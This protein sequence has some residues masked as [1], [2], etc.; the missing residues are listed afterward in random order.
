[1]SKRGRDGHVLL[2]STH[3]LKRH[4]PYQECLDINKR[5]CVHVSSFDWTAGRASNKRPAEFDNELTHLRKR[6]RATVPTAEEAIAFLIPHV[7]TLRNLYCESQHEKETLKVHLN[8]MN[9]AY[10]A[11]LQENGSLSQQL[12][13]SKTE[14][15]ALRRQ[16]E[17]MK[18]RLSMNECKSKNSLNLL[19]RK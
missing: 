5:Q 1:M 3:S 19:I 8:T 13:A 7:T 14:V 17:M 15:A 9:K 6:L 2:D 4:L 12:S 18:Y 11:S 16:V 10:Q